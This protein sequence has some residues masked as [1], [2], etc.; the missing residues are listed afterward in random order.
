MDTDSDGIPDYLDVESLNPKNDKT[1]FDIAK[2][3]FAFADTN[4]NGRLDDDDHY[5]QD[6][7]RN[8]LKDIAEKAPRSNLDDTELSMGCSFSGGVMK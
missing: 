7:N 5:H 2:T 1:D 6:L 8:G 4:N 3:V